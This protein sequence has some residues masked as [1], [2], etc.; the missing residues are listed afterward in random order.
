MEGNTF[1]VEKE[2]VCRWGRGAY[3]GEGLQMGI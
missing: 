2:G 3:E 1:K